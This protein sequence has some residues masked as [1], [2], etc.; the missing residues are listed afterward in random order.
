MC[1]HVSVFYKNIDKKIP[2]DTFKE[3]LDAIFHRGPD[4][5]GIEDFGKALLGFSRL[6]IIDLENGHQPF[7]KQNHTMIFNGEIYNYQ[8]LKED[9]LQKGHTFTTTSDTE[10]LLTSYLEYGNDCVA[11]LRGMFTFLIWDEE[12]QTMFGGADHYGIKPLYYIETE[13]Y[14]A[15]SSE[16]KGLLP[17]LETR[18]VDTEALQSYL[19]FQFVPLGKTMLKEVKKVPVGHYFEFKDNQLTFAPFHQL[20]YK[21]A[22]VTKEDVYN[23]MVES[24]K[25]HMIAD[26]EVGTFLSGGIDSSIIATIASELNPKIKSF[27]VGF[28]VEGYNEMPV[29][30]K[31]AEALGIENISHIITQ[32]EYIEHLPDFVSKL[33]DPM[34]DPSAP[35]IYFLSREAKKHVKV[36][37]SGE[38]SDEFF[39][40]YNIYKEYYSVK[41]L[42]NL[43]K[44]IKKAIHGIASKLPD[45]K[46]KSYLLRATSPLRDRY[47]GNAKIFENDQVASVMKNAN[48]NYTYQHVL[49]P[50]YDLCEKMGYDYVTTMQFIDMNTWL[51]GD[52]LIKGDKMSMAHSLE[53]RVPFLDK[54]VMAVASRLSLEQKVTKANTKVLLRQAFDGKIP[55]HVV[56]KKKLGF[57]TPI[58]VW[59]KSDLGRIVKDT[60]TNAQVDAY[61]N[62][63][64]V[65]HLLDEH[66]QGNKD[67]SRKVWTVFI[68]CLWHQLTIEQ[69]HIE[70]HV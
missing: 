21:E 46:G 23:V 20:Q 33:D 58:R 61:I 57:P 59:L 8:T 51:Q 50:L 2:L 25:A 7:H 39:G 70:F 53:L 36:V 5:T 37:M 44:P 60:I 13:D 62:K 10:V 11:K 45:I 56:E 31:T 9:L 6:S 54:E 30:K 3:G 47:I 43:P 18:T 32:K 40:G 29:A 28:D 35:G 34:A 27:T 12:N 14:V 55:Q 16:Y 1:G 69:K 17:F 68:F 64:Y 67:N 63:D 22:S 19:S 48:P 52:I 65:L 24:V 66:I 49:A 15:F 4:D 41:P 38:G 26:V 42:M